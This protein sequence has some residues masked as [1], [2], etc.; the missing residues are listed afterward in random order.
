MIQ[1][2]RWLLPLSWPYSA[3]VWLRNKLYDAGVLASQAP[4]GKSIAIG[5][6]ALGGT[7][8]TPHTDYLLRMLDASSTAVLSR[9]YG[10]QSSGF[11][12]V[13]PSANASDVGDE[14]LLLARKHPEALVL[15]DA[16]RL[17]GM[18]ELKARFPERKVVLLDDALQH[19]KLRAGFNLL[20]TTWQQP[21]TRDASL[22]AGNL[23]DHKLR[24]RH[25]HAV[26]VTKTPENSSEKDRQALRDELAYLGVPVFF[27]HI[28]YGDTRHFAGAKPGELKP[29]SCVLLLSAIADASLFEAHARENYKVLEH[30]NYRD[31]HRFTQADLQRIRDFIGSF[32]PGEV[33]VLS[34]EKDAMRLLPYTIDNEH[35]MPDMYYWEIAV[36]FGD[37]AENF[38]K[39]I[40]AYV[41]S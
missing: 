15:V 33:A 34:T 19:R 26:V 24:A 32:A 14:P 28:R 31:H 10:R 29:G 30:F 9:G 23:R 7:G 1:K 13:T 27:S 16:D 35:E 21:F 40:R 4:S 11:A 18:A 5:N 2:R 38:E 12:V 22:P 36:N 37:D 39:L 3:A 17:H 41:E 25:A 6:L 8:K 20:L